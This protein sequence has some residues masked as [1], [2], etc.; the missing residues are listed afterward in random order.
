MIAF[1]GAFI[2]QD[3]SARGV[4]SSGLLGTER[5][6]V[7]KPGDTTVDLEKAKIEGQGAKALMDTAISGAKAL[8][9]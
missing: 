4:A 7:L 9:G 2:S 5:N 3:S 8:K 1:A 6:F